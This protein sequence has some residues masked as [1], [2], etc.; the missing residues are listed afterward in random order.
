MSFI[1]IPFPGTRV[2]QKKKSSIRTPVEA[3]ALISETGRMRMA[4]V[5]GE[6]EDVWCDQQLALR[7]GSQKEDQRGESRSTF[8]VGAPSACR[9]MREQSGKKRQAGLNRRLP[10]HDLA[11]DTEAAAAEGYM[12]ASSQER[13]GY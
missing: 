2:S 5:G 10:S 8:L 11:R 4:L 7:F 1:T 13:S 6:G 12:F 9:V 3:D